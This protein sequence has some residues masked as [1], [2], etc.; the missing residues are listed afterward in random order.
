MFFVAYFLL[1]V[2]SNLLLERFGARR[3]IARIMFTWGLISGSFAFIPS[4]S[5][6]TGLSN[7]WTF[8][9]LRFLLG[10]CEAGFFPGVIFFLTLWFPSAYRARVISIFMLA[11]PNFLDHR[12]ADLRHSA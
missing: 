4:I 9:V 8:Y 6:A 3:W 12:R 7:E 2:P 5:H 11:I 10:I 1:E